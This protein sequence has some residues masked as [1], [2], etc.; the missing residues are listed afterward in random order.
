LLQVRNVLI[1]VSELFELGAEV[2]EL[3]FDD[4]FVKMAS[5]SWGKLVIEPMTCGCEIVRRELEY[6]FIEEGSIF[7]LN[8]I[9]RGGFG[10]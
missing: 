6:R 1:A 5:R 7:A 10:K 3:F 8:P 4:V 2:L 9:E